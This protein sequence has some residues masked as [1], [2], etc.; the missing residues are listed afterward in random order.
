MRPISRIAG[1]AA[2]LSSAAALAVAA[3]AMAVP[4]GPANVF[5]EASADQRQIVIKM[6]YAPLTGPQYTCFYRAT[7]L[8]GGEVVT[9]QGTQTGYAAVFTTLSPKSADLYAVTWNCPKVT[10]APGD[11]YD[12]FASSSNDSPTI[13]RIDGGLPAPQPGGPQIPGGL[14]GLPFGSS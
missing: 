2:V 3:P 13:V 5:P 8:G 12:L 9:G 6:Q 14:G 10:V 4:T 11:G 1:I 7:G